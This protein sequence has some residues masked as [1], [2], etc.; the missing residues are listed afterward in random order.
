MRYELKEGLA[1][2]RTFDNT[3]TRAGVDASKAMYELQ[4]RLRQFLH[5]K[6]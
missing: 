5:N 2:G 6:I 3:C 1:Q 4:V